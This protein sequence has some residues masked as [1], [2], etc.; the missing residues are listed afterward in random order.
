[1][2]DYG[3]QDEFVGV[4]HAVLRRIAPG[5]SV[6]DISHA[7]PRQDVWAGAMTLWRAAP[8]LPAGVVVAVVD[9]GVGTSR[10]GV[11]IEV[12]R[13]AGAGGQP[14]PA[15][16][17][18][19]LAG[20][21]PC[22]AGAGG[23]ETLV[24]VGPDNGLL[25]LAA[26]ASGTPTRAVELRTSALRAPQRGATFDGRDVFAPVAAYLASGVDL[27]ELGS[28]AALASLVGERRFPRPWKQ[29]DGIVSEVVWQD[30]YGNLQLS[31]TPADIAGAR[32]LRLT[33]PVSEEVRVVDAFAELPSGR[34]G[35]VVDSYGLL[36]LCVNGGSAAEVTGLATRS[37]V[38]LRPGM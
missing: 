37:T 11:A 33:G 34:L 12:A 38:G 32:T 16:N 21:Q 31:A 5:A 23:D 28:R 10:R 30:G 27:D 13:P 36:A 18:S 8:W 14:S 7:V 22:P 1:M 17:Q 29:E 35:V 9:P 19:R 4:L 6:I 24:F 26:Y 2:T 3:L 15:G 20:A 25:T